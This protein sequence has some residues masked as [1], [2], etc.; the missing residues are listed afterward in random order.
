MRK[1]KQNVKVAEKELTAQVADINEV[2]SML[3]QLSSEEK[4]Q[5]MMFAAGMRAAR[6]IYEPTTKKP[7]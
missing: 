1:E 6:D 4:K 5:L 7:A 3:K 2:M